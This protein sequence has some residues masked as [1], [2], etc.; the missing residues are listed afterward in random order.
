M[1]G[2][3]RKDGD[4]DRGERDRARTVLASGS[5]HVCEF[6][7]SDTARGENRAADRLLATARSRR[8]P[9]AP[10]GEN[11]ACAGARAG[12]GAPYVAAVAPIAV[13]IPRMPG[14]VMGGGGGEDS[15]GRGAV[16][17]TLRSLPTRAALECWI[18]LL[19]AVRISS[20][21]FPISF[22]RRCSAGNL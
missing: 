17:L 1:E 15:D 8:P 14:R 20:F 9:P 3:P 13:A 2:K 16:W 5:R 18:L 10:Q 19:A 11:A 21:F 22:F 7:E 12:I 6:R 4:F